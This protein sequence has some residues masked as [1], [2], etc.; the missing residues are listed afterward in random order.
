MSAGD[1]VGGERHSVTSLFVFFLIGSFAVL[2]VTLTLVGVRAYRNVAAVSVRNGDGQIALSYL[3]NK[4]R[5]QDARG[6]ATLRREG[7]TDVL[8]LREE[9]DGELYETRVFFSS[10]SLMEYYV[11]ADAPFDPEAGTSICRLSSLSMTLEEKNLLRLEAVQPDGRAQSLR[12]AL[13]GEA[14]GE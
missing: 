10:G 13:R 3:L 2:A 12:V 1:R 14:Y 5:A 4:V 8:C 6:M 11:E 9:I 7:D